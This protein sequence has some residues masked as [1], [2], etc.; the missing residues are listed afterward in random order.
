MSSQH[1]Q[2]GIVSPIPTSLKLFAEWLS[3]Q[4]LDDLDA[5]RMRLKLVSQTEAAVFLG[6]TTSAP[7]VL[8]PYPHSSFCRV[9]LLG[10]IKKGGAKYLSPRDSGCAPLYLADRDGLDWG[11]VKVD[12][13]V[14]VVIT[15]GEVKGYWGAKSGVSTIAIGGV[16]MQATLF[17]SGFEWRDR[18]VM[19]AFDHD[20][21]QERGGYK[22][23][24]G[25]ALGKLCSALIA[26]GAAVQ[27]LTI[28]LLERLDPEQ[29]WGLD[30][31]LRAGVTWDELMTT[32]RAPPDWCS[33]LSELLDNCVFVTGTNHV[34]VYHLRNGSRKSPS[35]FHD[36]HVEKV[37]KVVDENGKVKLQSISKQWVLHPGRLTVENYDLD[38]RH[39]FGVVNHKIN[40]W[41]GYPQYS[42]QDY[43]EATTEVWQRFMEGVFGE[44][45]EWVGLWAGH[46][47][48]RPWEPTNQAVMLVTSVQGVGKS[49]W[50]E[51][52]KDLCGPHG[53]ECSATRMFDSF[54]AS[55]EGKT[56]VMVN[57]LDIKF[58][59]KE[60]ALN[61]LLSEELVKVEQ[62]GK[63]VIELPN[64]RR[65]YM[66]TNTS[67]P[68]RLSR[69]QRRVLVIRPP[70]VLA[71]TR[72]E[73]GQWVGSVVAAIRRDE[74]KLAAVRRWFDK[75]WFE[76]GKGE[77]V[78]ESTKPV[79]ITE[80]AN[81][82][83]EASM[84]ESQL[85]VEHMLQWLMERESGW[86]AVHPN[87]RKMHN[88]IWGEISQSVKDRGG[89]VMGK[90]VKIDGK[91]VQFTVFD[92]LG[93][94]E[95]K[96]RNDGGHWAVVEASEVKDVMEETIKE[97][98][99][100]N[101]LLGEKR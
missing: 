79:P 47:L 84:T 77:G 62:K 32:L 9:R 30:D 18:V 44:Y 61:D 8:I 2:G 52:I 39:K 70:R 89:W 50:G 26:E 13:S 74:H 16:E 91:L 99:N 5:A 6:Y 51:I 55:M 49:L 71:D 45:W 19:V 76:S 68:A 20:P 15:E 100:I 11:D 38:P 53:L 60:G 63:D 81:D 31:A 66:T 28:G 22:P 75:L 80:A 96:P 65:W 56:F 33:H 69:G 40:L 83:A 59:S 85:V 98:T 58:S 87:Q 41:K 36:T 1:D 3:A 23:Q 90:M 101:N 37:R 48:N 97:F 7:G 29:K 92:I 82:V 10:P 12:V 43:D 24:V 25:N 88:K 72:G 67:S 46:L 14:P 64:L 42:M 54:N 73:W 57:E 94:V 78:W 21:G 95:R 27:V 4:G 35:D 17:N 86:M 93:K 34:H